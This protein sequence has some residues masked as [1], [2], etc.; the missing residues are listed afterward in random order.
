MLACKTSKIICFMKLVIRK[1]PGLVAHMPEIF[2]LGRQRQEGL[3][4]K[5]S[6]AYMEKLCLG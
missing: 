6:L 5:A 3:R 2:S 4:F 1:P